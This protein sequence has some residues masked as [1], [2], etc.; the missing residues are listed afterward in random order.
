MAGGGRDIDPASWQ[1]SELQHGPSLWG[2][3]RD[4][5][6]DDL[7][8]EARRMRL[9]AAAQGERAPLRVWTGSDDM[10]VWFDPAT[11]LDELEEART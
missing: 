8:A 4:W 1:S 11:G 5:L 10:G 7:K 6:S 3:D 9:A 2:H